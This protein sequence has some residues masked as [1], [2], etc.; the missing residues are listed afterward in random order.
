MKRTVMA[1]VTLLTVGLLYPVVAAVPALATSP[2]HVSFTLEGCKDPSSFDEDTI[3]CDD[4]D[5]TTGNLGKDWAELDLVPYRLT[6]KATNAAPGTQTYDITLVLDN[7]DAGHH[8]YYVIGEPVINDALSD[9]SCAIVSFS[10]QQTTTGFGG[11]DQSIYREVQISQDKGDT[12]VLDYYGGLAV[13]AH[14]FPGGSLHANVA[15]ENLNTAN[16]GARDVSIIPKEIAPQSISKDM[17]A[18]RDASVTWNLTKKPQP[19]SLDFG[20]P[21]DTTNFDSTLPVDVTVTWTKGDAVDAD[22]VK[23]TTN[24]YATNP[25]QREITVNVTDII[26]S[27]TTALD[28]FSGSADIPA[29]TTALVFTHEV[30]IDATDAVLLNDIATASYT[31]KL[32]GFPVPGTT[33]AKASVTEVTTGTI[34]N[35]DARVRDSESITGTGLT[36][37]VEAPSVGAFVGYT[38]GTDTVGPV[39]WASGVQTATGSVTFHKTVTY[40]PT[41]GDTDGTLSDIAGLLGSGGQQTYATLDIA[42]TGTASGSVTVEKTTSV[43]V[44]GDTDFVFDVVDSSDVVVDTI[45]I[46][47]PDGETGPVSGTASN[48][49]LGDYTLVETDSGD[50]PPAGDAPF[51]LA[52]GECDKT[53]EIENT[54]GPAT[55]TAQK[56]TDPAGNEEGWTFNLM[57]DVTGDGPSAD[58]TVY[59]SAV[60]D[61]SGLADFGA[62]A[63]EGDYYIVEE[64]QVGWTSDGGKGTECAFT[65]D[66]PAD[67]DRLFEDCTFTNTARGSIGITKTGGTAGQ[68]FKFE[69]RGDD[70]VPPTNGG[71]LLDTETVTSGGAQVLF[72]ING[73]TDLP[74]GDYTVCEIIPAAGW[75]SDLGGANQYNLT[76]A[77]NE[78]RVCTDVSITIDNQDLSITVANTPPPGGERGTLGFWKTHSCE[79][80]GKQT[81][82]VTKNLPLPLGSYTVTDCHVAVRILSKQ[83]TAKQNKASDPLF[84]MAA[85]LLAAE[86]NVKAGASTC[87]TATSV[88]S[89]ANALLAKYSWTPVGNGYTGKLSAADKTLAGTLATQLDAYNNGGLC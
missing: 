60:T 8:G 21:C 81:D 73:S 44:D 17:S 53:V 4:N 65:V 85:Q 37:S 63:D 89:Q 26:Y 86:L 74:L 83:N 67:S 51:S 3:T 77:D 71:T 19:A 49:A 43:P 32:T 41:Q 35:T 55:A 6:A 1:V 75:S 40:D 5:Y 13:G 7:E 88:I 30:E 58:D 39:N 25:A 87:P 23:V 24:V 38:A 50:F 9:D 45:T 76:L 66:L 36:F 56:V 79:A 70:V 64:G 84:N 48:L 18:V 31:D 61:S 72:K 82:Q 34:S 10:G 16:I 46:T 12:C 62:V 68:G 78:I 14:L 57:L 80:P 2:D 47:I 15:D 28:S 27:D 52:L 54:A 20:N 69:L 33:E 42:I 22:T 11:I 29:N 59:A